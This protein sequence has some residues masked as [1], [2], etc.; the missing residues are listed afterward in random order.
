MALLVNNVI[1]DYR[2]IR[3][4]S[5]TAVECFWNHGEQDDTKT[6]RLYNRKSNIP[7]RSK[8]IAC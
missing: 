7:N 2:W 4:M 8:I 6:T 3:E 5:Q 1:F